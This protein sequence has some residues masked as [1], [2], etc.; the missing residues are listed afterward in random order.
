MMWGM[1]FCDE[2]RARQ[3]DGN[4]LTLTLS[5]KG[6]GEGIG[7]RSDPPSRDGFSGRGG[8]RNMRFYETNRIGFSTISDITTNGYASCVDVLKNLNPVRLERKRHSGGPG[9]RLKNRT[10]RRRSARIRE[11]RWQWT[12]SGTA[13]LLE[14][15]LTRRV[16]YHFESS[17][18]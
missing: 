5:P 10:D 6:R 16:V 13:E 2:I 12:K 7:W 1:V 11:R 17:F 4:P 14:K 3:R 9:I 15:L 8:P 18:G